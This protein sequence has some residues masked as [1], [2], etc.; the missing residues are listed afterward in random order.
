[1]QPSIHLHFFCLMRALLLCLCI[2]LSRWAFRLISRGA[3]LHYALIGSQVLEPYFYPFWNYH[4]SVFSMDWISS[5]WTHDGLWSLGQCLRG[6]VGRPTH[7]HRRLNDVCS[8]SGGLF[9]RDFH[10]V[11]LPVLLSDLWTRY[12]LSLFANHDY[13]RWLLREISV[14]R[15]WNY[16]LRS[17]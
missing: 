4:A 6:A 10:G 1:M 3:T 2:T 15:H 5:L 12:L 17:V 16:C 8:G 11:A 7:H 9:F 14:S 13:R